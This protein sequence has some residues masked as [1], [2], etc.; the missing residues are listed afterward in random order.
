MDID[1][2]TLAYRA[3]G[4]SEDSAET[5]LSSGD[6]EQSIYDRYGCDF[7]TYSK[8]VSDLLPF[9]FRYNSPLS[10]TEFCA[11]VDHDKSFAILKATM[12]K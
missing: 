1:M 3:M 11:F 2:E 9:A 8:I 4:E 12:E 5:L 7:E 10:K 6:I